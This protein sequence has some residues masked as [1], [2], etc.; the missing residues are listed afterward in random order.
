MAISF[1]QRVVVPDDVLVRE[2]D[3]ESVLLN[4][5]TDS[6]FGLDA[7][8]TDMWRALV[9][10]ASIQEAYELMLAEYEVVPETLLR[11]LAEL[12]EKLQEHGLVEM[13]S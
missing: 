11:D 8:G 4:L 3:G 2:L 6:Y 13:S 1:A 9:G 5:A 12:V 10:S 7:V